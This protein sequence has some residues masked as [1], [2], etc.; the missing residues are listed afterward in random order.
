M[1]KRY[2]KFILLVS[3]LILAAC[4]AANTK[5]YERP[6]DSETEPYLEYCVSERLE[7]RTRVQLE[8]VACKSA[9]QQ[10]LARY[11]YCRRYRVYGCRRPIEPCSAPQFNRCTGGYDVGFVGC[12]GRILNADG[13]LAGQTDSRVSL[14]MSL[15][16]D[17]RSS[18]DRC[19][20]LRIWSLTV[21]T[22]NA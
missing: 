3:S 17:C 2:N 10:E 11:E 9:H 18:G 14:I 22:A 19:S 12:G 4:S 21:A 16:E 6:G 1:M 7:C 20:P 8:L 13:V 15:N 5:T